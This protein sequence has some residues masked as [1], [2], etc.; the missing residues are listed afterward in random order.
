VQKGCQIEGFL[1]CKKGARLKISKSAK[2]V[3]D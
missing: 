1:E 3:P 2:R